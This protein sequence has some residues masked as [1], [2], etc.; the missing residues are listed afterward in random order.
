MRREHQCLECDNFF[1][2]SYKSGDPIVYCPFCG[3]AL[4]IAESNDF[5]EDDD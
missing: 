2:I 4:E 1:V 5:A 3:E